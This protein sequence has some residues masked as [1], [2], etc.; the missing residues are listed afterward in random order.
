MIRKNFNDK[1]RKYSVYVTT[2][3]SVERINI[4]YMNL[5]EVN[6][7]IEQ[8]ITKGTYI[9][10]EYGNFDYVSVIDINNIKTIAEQIEKNKMIIK[11]IKKPLEVIEKCTQIIKK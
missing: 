11:T 4:L 9:C 1:R 3:T 5:D 8:L 7:T 2:K 6:D 10:N